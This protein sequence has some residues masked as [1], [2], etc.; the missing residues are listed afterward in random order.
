MTVATI[1]V[2]SAATVNRAAADIS[3]VFCHPLTGC[4]LKALIPLNI[5]SLMM[6]E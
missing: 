4:S 2:R 3:R 1:V 6:K 5:S